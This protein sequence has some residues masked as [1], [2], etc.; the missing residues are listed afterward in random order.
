MDLIDDI[1]F[2]LNNVAFI[3]MEEDPSND[4]YNVESNEEGTENNLLWDWNDLNNN[5]VLDISTDEYEKFDDFGLDSCSDEYERGNTWIDMLC[6]ND[7]YENKIDCLCAT[8]VDES[9]YNIEY[10]ENTDII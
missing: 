3:Y 5:Q 4:N 2:Y 8:N 10:S 9:L 1:N 7:I 6:S